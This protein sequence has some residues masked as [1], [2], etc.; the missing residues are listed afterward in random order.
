MVMLG[1]EIGVWKGAK[2]QEMW[3]DKFFNVYHGG[4]LPQMN[5]KGDHTSLLH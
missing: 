4:V 1:V 2:R 3:Y 5:T